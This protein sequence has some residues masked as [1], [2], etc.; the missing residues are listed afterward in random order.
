M[1]WFVALALFNGL[2]IGIARSV[3]GRLSVESGPFTASLWNHLVGFALLSLIL[4]LAGSL[5]FQQAAEAPLFSYLGGVIGALYVAIN[6]YVLSRIGSTLASL[7]VISG[8][9]ACGVLLEVVL[10]DSGSLGAKLLGVGLILCGV[11]LSQ[12][13]KAH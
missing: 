9:M 3:N 11:Y 13:A 8:Q 2:L 5:S 4:L 6:S 12:R 1:L 7:L 10:G